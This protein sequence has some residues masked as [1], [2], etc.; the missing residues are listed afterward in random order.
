MSKEG[1]VGEEEA[2]KREVRDRKERGEGGGGGHRKGERERKRKQEE[3]KR[4]IGRETF[5][6][7][8]RY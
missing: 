7:I 5:K 4:K 3:G 1:R 6:L 2:Y 8:V